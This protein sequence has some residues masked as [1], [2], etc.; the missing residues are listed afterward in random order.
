VLAGALLLCVLLFPQR[1]GEH[2][3]APASS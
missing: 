1:A 3:A 2:P